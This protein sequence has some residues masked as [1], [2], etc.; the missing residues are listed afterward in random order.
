MRV[1]QQSAKILFIF[2]GLT[3]NAHST[4]PRPRQGRGVFGPLHKIP[5]TD[6][7]LSGYLEALV[8]DNVNENKV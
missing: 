4:E 3:L 1:M 2:Q 5:G 6:S 8:I 7:L